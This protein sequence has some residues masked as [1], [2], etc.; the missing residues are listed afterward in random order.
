MAP[1]DKDNAAPDK[2]VQLPLPDSGNAAWTPAD[3][4]ALLV[5]L[6]DEKTATG[7]NGQFKAA[8]LR[9][10]AAALNL[11]QTR[12]GPKMHQGCGQKYRQ[13]RKSW[14]LVDRIID[15]SG[16]TWSHQHGVTVDASTQ[17]A[18][19]A[20]VKQFPE[21][22][23]FRNQ[24]WPFYDLMAPLMPT[25]AKGGNVFCANVPAA[26]S[27]ASS[28]PWDEE[29]MNNDFPSDQDNEDEASGGDNNDDDQAPGSSSL[30]DNEDDDESDVCQ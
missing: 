8:T 10:A 14:G 1:A 30:R 16:W 13:H 3:D 28:P 11:V 27:K 25:K 20:F 4:R 29:R 2:A 26:P 19:D 9:G 23:R 22:A 21:A 24:G 18:W 17:G 5:Y 15:T 6:V 7:D 12:G